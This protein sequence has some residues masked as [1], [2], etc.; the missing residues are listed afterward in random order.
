VQLWSLLEYLTGMSRDDTQKSVIRR[1]LFMQSLYGAEKLRL[2]EQI[3]K[4]LMDHRNRAVHAQHDASEIAA[5]VIQLRR[6]VEDLLRFHLSWTPRFSSISDAAAF[7][8][9]TPDASKL[10]QQVSDLRQM[11]RARERALAR[12][13]K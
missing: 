6:Y 1:V 2:H 7:L 10:Q 5:F 3:L 13:S 9:L 4:H 11:I 8:S 12:L